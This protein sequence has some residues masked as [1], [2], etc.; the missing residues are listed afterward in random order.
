MTAEQLAFLVFAV[1]L[2]QRE[3]RRAGILASL[4]LAQAIIESDWGRSILATKGFN[5]FGIK[6]DF[7]GQSI[8][9]N[10]GEYINGQAIRVVAAFRKYPDVETG[11]QDHSNFLRRSH[12]S[13]AWWETDIDK[14][15]DA[16]AVAGYATSPTY[17]NTLKSC[18]KTYN[19]TQYDVPME[20][21]MIEPLAINKGVIQGTNI[22]GMPFLVKIV[23]PSGAANV[24]TGLKLTEVIGVTIHN[25]A[26]PAPSADD[27]L[28]ALWLQNV[29]NAD[30][31]YISVHFFVDQDSIT[32]VVPVDEV[33]FHAGDGKGNGNRKTIA[34]E[35]CENGDKVR[36]EKNAQVLTAALLK[37]YPGTMV[38]KHQ[39]WSGKF[40]PRVI[41]GR[42]GW[43]A[44]K[45]GIY[46]LLDEVPQVE[47]PK[48]LVRIT[49]QN[50]NIRKG[51]G[52]IY[53]KA[54]MVHLGSIYTIVEV[55]GNWGRLK[56]GAGW[57]HLGFTKDV[58]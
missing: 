17:A 2:A 13:K 56:S 23:S 28:H 26:N 16:I 12:Y 32:Q 34:I 3:A 40:C 5:Y 20:V 48:K 7:L 25:T 6:G 38:F 54:G 11:F 46:D 30:Q 47:P 19:L 44:F 37:T 49:V 57:I 42:N 22:E 36:A 18:V 53:G 8:T 29:E 10:T 43:D 31:Q 21:P 58:T 51:P 27:N 41:L 50:L 33:C 45:V 9:K 15:I 14:A 39:D 4:T 35:I 52:V 1:P 24:R 55:K